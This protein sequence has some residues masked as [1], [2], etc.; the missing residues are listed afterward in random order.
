MLKNLNA[1]VLAFDEVIGKH[2]YHDQGNY[3]PSSIIETS[4]IIKL[5]ISKNCFT[6]NIIYEDLEMLLKII[7]ST[8]YEINIQKLSQNDSYFLVGW[9]KHA[10]FLFYE[11]QSNETYNFGLI[12]A[13]DGIEYQGVENDLCNGII[14]FNNI[15]WENIKNFLL[16][17]KNYYEITETKSSSE[18]LTEYKLDLFYDYYKPLPFYFLL[19]KYL[20]GIDDVNINFNKLN[21][22][23]TT[24]KINSQI[25]GSCTF[26]NHI[27]YLIYILYKKNYSENYN[28]LYNNWYAEAKKVIKEV[29]YDEIIESND[30]ANYYKYKYI[31]ESLGKKNEK[32]ENIVFNTKITNSSNI[33]KLIKIY[34]NNIFSRNFINNKFKEMHKL[35]KCELDE[36]LDI[37][38]DLYD[39]KNEKFQKKYGY[40]INNILS[41]SPSERPENLKIVHNNINILSTFYLC[42]NQLYNQLDNKF[43]YYTMLLEL[44]QLKKANIK[45]INYVCEHINSQIKIYFDEVEEKDNEY[46]NNYILIWSLIIT[47][48]NNTDNDKEEYSKEDKDRCNKNRKIYTRLLSVIPIINRYYFNITKEIINEIMEKI[49]FFPDINDYE[50]KKKDTILIYKDANNRYYYNKSYKVPLNK[51]KNFSNFSYWFC[52]NIFTSKIDKRTNV[53]QKNIYKP[54]FLLKCMSNINNFNTLDQISFQT[55]DNTMINNLENISYKI[56]IYPEFDEY[57]KYWINDQMTGLLNNKIYSYLKC[58]TNIESNTEIYYYFIYFYLCELDGKNIEKDI[59]LKFKDNVNKYLID[60]I[61]DENNNAKPLFLRYILKNNLEI[62]AD[63][64]YINID[65][66]N[67]LIP[68]NDKKHFTISRYKYKIIKENENEEYC[69]SNINFYLLTTNKLKF[70]FY[71]ENINNESIKIIKSIIDDYNKYNIFLVLNFNFSYKEDNIIGTHRDREWTLEII[72][73]TSKFILTIKGIKYQILENNYN[74]TNDHVNQFFNFITYKNEIYLLCKEESKENTYFIYLYNYDLLFIIENNEVYYELKS[75]KYKVLFN[76]DEDTYKNYNILKLLDTTTADIKLFC[77]YDYTLILNDDNTNDDIEYFIDYDENLMNNLPYNLQKIKDNKIKDNKDYIQEY[78]FSIMDSFNGKFILT[79]IKDVYAILFNCLLNNNPYLIIKL[80][81]QIKIILNNYSNK[82]DALILLIKLIKKFT[83]IYSLIISELLI[84]N[85]SNIEKNILN[86]KLNRRLNEYHYNYY[87]KILLKYTCI[88]LNCNISEHIDGLIKMTVPSIVEDLFI[89]N[90]KNVDFHATKIVMNNIFY[91]KKQII[92]TIENEENDVNSNFNYSFVKNL[93]LNYEIE[94]YNLLKK[95]FKLNFNDNNFKSNILKANDFFNYLIIPQKKY[96]FPI[97]EL[98]MGSGKSTVITPYMCILFINY[99]MKYDFNREIYIIMPKTLIEQSFSIFMTNLFPLYQNVE[100]LLFGKESL[101]KDSIKIFLINDTQ[102]KE[103][104]LENKINTENKYMI[105]DEVD[106]MANPLTCELNIPQ[107]KDILNNFDFLF[108]LT[109]NIYNDLFKSNVFWEQLQSMNV[110]FINNNLHNYIITKLTDDQIKFINNYFDGV[111]KDVDSIV[112]KNYFKDNI[113]FFILTNQFNYNYGLPNKYDKN[114]NLNDKYQ[115]KAIPYGGGDLPLFGS[116]FSDVILSFVLTYFSYKLKDPIYRKIDMMIILNI[117][118]NEYRNN[119]DEE[120]RSEIFIIFQNC[121]TNKPTEISQYY[122]NKEFYLTHLSEENNT[123]QDKYFEKF[124]DL[125]LKKNIEYNKYCNNISFNDL[126]LFKNV[127]NVISFTGTAYITPPS[128]QEINYN[129]NIIN[130]ST[131]NNYKNVEQAIKYLLSDE[132]K[133]KNYF[134]NTKI[135]INDLFY[136]LNQYDVLIDIGAIL[137]NFTD[138]D[139]I[140]KFKN[141]SSKKKYIVY[142]DNGIK[143][144]NLKSNKFEN[145]NVITKN[146]NDVFYYFSNKNITGVDAKEIMYEQAHGLIT[147]SN[148]TTLRDFSQGIFRMRNILDDCKQTADIIINNKMINT[149]GTILRG[150]GEECSKYYEKKNIREKLFNGLKENQKNLDDQ[151]YKILLKQNILALYKINTTISKLI[152]FED[153]S[154]SISRIDYNS[155][156]RCYNINLNIVLSI[157]DKNIINIL[158]DKSLNRYILCMIK[159]YFTYDNN[160]VTKEIVINQNQEQEEEQ[161]Q[162]Q[163]E[164]QE[165]VKELEKKKKNISFKKSKLHDYNGKC[166]TNLDFEYNSATYNSNSIYFLN[167]IDA[168][169]CILYNKNK[170]IICVLNQEEFKNFMICNDYNYIINEYFIAIIDLEYINKK[171]IT[172]GL[173]IENQL[174]IILIVKKLS[175]SYIFDNISFE[176]LLSKSEIEYLKQKNINEI[177]SK[178]YKFIYS[179]NYIYNDESLK[180]KYL[181]YKMKYLKISRLKL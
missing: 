75:E 12:N 99:F 104:F 82:D 54:S 30:I 67:I 39:F 78:Y 170:N 27:S 176:E 165:V 121:F 145:K 80:I 148:H 163:E 81:P 114:Y 167:I 154:N 138:N 76:Y 50:E 44:Y 29:L 17:Y 180:K 136:C 22:K 24:L 177:I 85:Y 130:Y 21:S 103:M 139:F 42:F 140:N 97:Q 77:L 112:L 33:Y 95:K 7:K 111:N 134:V 71:K 36:Y 69:L 166:Y 126:L 53:I 115:F 20:L 1:N 173:N 18:I 55:I 52:H 94:F 101:I 34:Y 92:I 178:N 152:L 60:N 137:I 174:E 16:K 11:K 131:V 141:T 48:L 31:I 89:F 19:V 8:K 169:F 149:N 88:K 51:R 40:I 66:Y 4:A 125:I 26:T 102:Y 159:N 98:I 47:I 100:I 84:D 61:K 10:I 160:S 83:N 161:E 123:F 168:S 135:L 25:L 5:L 107:D 164:E 93:S 57:G 15:N 156:L 45:F 162:E 110:Q 119:H 143:I 64:L 28:L 151:K 132:K 157:D 38:W 181:K 147:I 56:T 127:K 117:I 35:N 23:F 118:E 113:L 133:I 37:F 90:L 43:T 105:Y 6:E 158:K 58:I 153:P 13:G 63:Y 175:S 70:I 74:F 172:Y 65:N 116:E 41:G 14:I 32:Y 146:N 108:Q 79:N 144:Y 59:E 171:Y 124:I 155:I 3:R 73:S 87:N 68:S 96:L 106:M 49:N 142:F 62:S 91:C 2:S 129:N 72:K 109:K 150:G 120:T 122:I 9:K 179:K 46:V 128:E 86:L